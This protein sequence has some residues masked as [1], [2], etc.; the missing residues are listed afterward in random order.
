MLGNGWGFR[1]GLF[2]YRMDRD[3]QAT[4]FVSYITALVYKLIQKKKKKRL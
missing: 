2:T 3:Y 4:G 1:V